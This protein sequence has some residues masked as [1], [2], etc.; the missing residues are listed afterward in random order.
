MVQVRGYVVSSLALA[1][2]IGCSQQPEP[3]AEREGEVSSTRAANTPPPPSSKEVVFGTTPRSVDVALLANWVKRSNDNQGQAFAIID[4]KNARLFVFTP[5][6][7]VAGVSPIILGSAKGDHTAPGVGDKP[8][9]HVL[10]EERT[11]PAGRFVG[12]H[13]TNARAEQIIWI[14]YDAAVSIHPV[15]TTNPKE[16]RLERLA[17]KDPE[18]R[19]ISYGCVNVPTQFFYNVLKPTLASASPVIY[20]LPEANPLTRTFPAVVREPDRGAVTRQHDLFATL[21]ARGWHEMRIRVVGDRIEVRAFDQ[22]GASV[23]AM[24]DGKSLEQVDLFAR[25]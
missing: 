7:E 18:V 6:A 23:D 9:A 15:L 19:R 2:L 25:G 13:G 24:F 1:A 4:K 8:I 22:N 16:R 3:L 10:P 12:L 14:D 17:A 11:T 5:S 21:A 20:V